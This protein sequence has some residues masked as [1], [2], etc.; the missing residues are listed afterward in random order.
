M[1]SYDLDKRNHYASI[2]NYIDLCNRVY[3]EAS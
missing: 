1:Y 2:K 3:G